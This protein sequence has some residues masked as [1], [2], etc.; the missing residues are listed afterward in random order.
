MTIKSQYSGSFLPLFF[1]PKAA[2]RAYGSFHARCQS[3]AV[4]TSLHH[5]HARSEPHLRPYTAAHS[6]GRILK[7]LRE[8]RDQTSWILVGSATTEP[9]QKLLNVVILKKKRNIC[10]IS[11]EEGVLNWLI[12]YF[13]EM[14]ERATKMASNLR[15]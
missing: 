6:Q 9:W 2:P 14:R 3:G 4:A 15:Y 12:F 1:S 13:S 5:R 10:C 7:P 8:A 11:K